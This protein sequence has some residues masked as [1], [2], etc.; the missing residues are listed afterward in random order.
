MVARFVHTEEVTGSNP[1][2]PTIE[3]R[4]RRVRPSSRLGVTGFRKGRNARLALTTVAA[5]TRRQPV[6]ALVLGLVAALLGVVAPTATAADPAP[7]TATFAVGGC[8][9]TFR[10]NYPV[11]M[12]YTDT[13]GG[14]YWVHVKATRRY[15]D[16]RAEMVLTR[17]PLVAGQVETVDLWLT[18]YL[19]TGL[20]HGYVTVTVTAVTDTLG[21]RPKAG[22]S[23][24][25]RVFELPRCGDDPVPAR[26]SA[27]LVKKRVAKKEVRQA[28][29][30]L[31]AQSMPGL[32]TT[33][34]VEMRKANGAVRNR[35][36]KVASGSTRTVAFRRLQRASRLVV[37]VDGGNVF[38]RSFALR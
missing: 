33:F 6:A 32:A 27:K 37:R 14:G 25:T 34:W 12:T 17:D 10:D 36:V 31:S 18:D 15:T 26:L 13:S 22:F 9:E 11:K 20:P 8:G 38:M 7:G 35:P 21:D 5:M 16:D 1:V 30:R 19:F 2:S 28:V 4:T 24:I 3:G 29:V 23:P